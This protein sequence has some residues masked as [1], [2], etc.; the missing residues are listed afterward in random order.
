VL[1]VRFGGGPRRLYPLACADSHGIQ[2]AIADAASSSRMSSASR[3]PPWRVRSSLWAMPCPSRTR[4][5]AQSSER[6]VRA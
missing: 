1:I 6:A 3:C 4:R 2:K 5:T